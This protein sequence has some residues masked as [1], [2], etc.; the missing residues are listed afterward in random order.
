MIWIVLVLIIFIALGQYVRGKAERLRAEDGNQSFRG[1]LAEAMR[2]PHVVVLI[3]I[4]GP[5][6]NP[7]EVHQR[8]AIEDEIEKRKLGN[9]ADAGSE[10]G[11]MHMLVV[12]AQGDAQRCADG[13][14]EILGSLQLL[15]RSRI[16]VRATAGP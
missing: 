4:S 11:A 13:I 10:N 1:S 16:D 14:S 5:M 8:L 15:G 6:A 12:A 3:G 7:D 2:R 9:V